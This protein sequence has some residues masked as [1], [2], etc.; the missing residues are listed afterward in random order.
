MARTRGK[1]K[2]KSEAAREALLDA[3]WEI[4]VERG[5]VPGLD[6]VTLQ[7]SIARSGVPRT[8]AYRV[9]A[10][11]EGALR[12]F[13]DALLA[14]IQFGLD[15]ESSF[16][17]VADLLAESAD[18]IEGD[19]GVAKA[20]LF[21][22]MIR[23]GFNDR[24]ERLS[25]TP[26]WRAYISTIAAM[27]F[28]GSGSAPSEAA[29]AGDRF[30]PLF[31]AMGEIFGFRPRSGLE[32]RTF[33]G[34]LVAAVDGSAIRMLED[35]GFDSIDFMDGS[36]RLWNGASIIALSLFLVWCEPD[37]EAETPA[38]LATWTAFGR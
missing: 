21:R 5:L 6:R 25:P 13:H 22:E 16:E 29:D 3:G 32:W 11:P 9:F 12:G 1:E 23:I 36:D 20:G 35:P 37:P 34:V 10:G 17:L 26:A 7:E 38:D 28:G 19:D 8:T 2:F 31:Q 30:V 18:I 33:A 24:L 15:A 4:L 14:R 27:K